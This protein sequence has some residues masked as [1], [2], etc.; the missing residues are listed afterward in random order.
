MAAGQ[1]GSRQRC[2]LGQG[3][4][5]RRQGRGESRLSLFTLSQV[6]DSR[7]PADQVVAEL[8]RSQG[9]RRKGRGRDRAGP[10]QAGRRARGELAVTSRGEG[11]CKLTPPARRPPR[12]RHGRRAR[13]TRPSRP[14]RTQ[15]R[16]PSRRLGRR[17]TR[18]RRRPSRPSATRSAKPRAGGTGPAT[19]RTRAR[20]RSRTGCSRRSGVSSMARKRRSTRPR[21]SEVVFNSCTY[22][23][24]VDQMQ[25]SF[26]LLP[27]LSRGGESGLTPDDRI[28]RR[29]A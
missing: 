19:R 26:V 20:S 5:P 21:S 10:H 8:G 9:R 14:F 17:T 24:E 6:T 3:D 29:W 7:R 15:R 11:G 13:R 2:R 23:R 4:L 1:I 16:L 27:T 25:F 18:R 22:R 28:S 12:G